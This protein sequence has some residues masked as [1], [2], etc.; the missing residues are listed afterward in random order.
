MRVT[1]VKFLKT[2]THDNAFDFSMDK[3]KPEVCFVGRSNVGKSSLLNSIFESKS[4]VKTSS[5]PW[6]TK[7]ANQFLLNKKFICVDLPGYGFAKLSNEERARIDDMI[8]A[9]ISEF[10]KD[11]RKVVIILDSKVGATE[12]DI[13]MF[14]FLQKLEIPCLIVLNKID[15][16][17]ASETKK[18]K[19]K[20]KETFVGQQIITYSTT[21]EKNKKELM[22]A[23]FGDIAL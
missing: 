12:N 7:F 22:W 14:L 19:E 1:E 16:L 4:I 15:K 5:K 20:A 11:V 2:V 6:H 17:N 21:K 18:A 3:A 13:D 23:I 8:T 10:G 9:Y